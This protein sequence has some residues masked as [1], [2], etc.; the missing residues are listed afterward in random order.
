MGAGGGGARGRARG[1]GALVVEQTTRQLQGHRKRSAFSVSV[2]ELPVSSL[3]RS[4]APQ[5]PSSG[6]VDLTWPS[7]RLRPPP[8]SAAP[9]RT[10]SSS[11]S[12]RDA[13]PAHL[14][15]GR[16]I[17]DS[18]RPPIA[19]RRTEKAFPAQAQPERG[20]VETAKRKGRALTRCLV[21]VA[22]RTLLERVHR[23]R[24]RVGGAVATRRRRRRSC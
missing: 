14:E 5:L 7:R 15:P 2:F 4:S 13:G 24:G 16:V 19:Q 22:T 6:Q 11:P 17:L 12:G 9:S 8:P 21:S 10:P 3:L 20:R 1:G 18:P 23:R